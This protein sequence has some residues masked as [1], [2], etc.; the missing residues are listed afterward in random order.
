MSVGLYLQKAREAAGYSVDDVARHTRIR[1]KVIKDLESENFESSGGSAYAKGHIRNIATYI[2]AD[3]EKAIAAFNE[4]TQESN[5]S[6]IE[7]LE[8]NSATVLR[9]KSSR[10]VAL[11]PKLMGLVASVIVGVA[12]IIP[13]GIALTSTTHHKS[14]APVTTS[15]QQVHAS[16]STTVSG[17]VVASHALLITA[18]SGSSWLFVT[19]SQGSQL[20]SGIL[21]KGASQTF[22]PTNGL[23]MKIG[24]AGAVAVSINGKDQGSIGSLGEVKTL[25]F[26]PAQ[27]NG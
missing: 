17:Q 5:R 24:N 14:S 3:V 23:T 10:K 13:T 26:S 21:S 22:D 4:R 19:D 1:P 20:F 9:R 27:S 16:T 15:V 8:E 25:T 6:M 7:L 11:S 12:I 18:T 2:G